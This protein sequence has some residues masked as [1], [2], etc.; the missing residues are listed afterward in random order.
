MNTYGPAECSVDVAVGGP[1]Q[2]PSDASTIGFPL[3]VCL[4]V[5][6]PSNYNR[7]VPIGTPGEL[8]VEGPQLAREYLNSPRKTDESFISDPEFVKQLGIP[9]HR[10]FY[11]TGDLVR[12]NTDGSLIH[13]G[14]IDTQIKIRGQRVEIGEIESNILRLEPKVRVACVDLIQLSDTDR[15]PMLLAAVEV[16][17]EEGEHDGFTPGP[18]R[19]PTDSLRALIRNLQAE[20]LLVLPRY[21]VPHFVPMVRLQLNASGKLDRRATR[22]TLEAMTREQVALFEEACDT[23]QERTTLSAMEER[24]RQIWVELLG[25]SPNVGPDANFT[26]LGGDSVIAMRHVAAA[27]RVGIQ[28]GV[29]DILHN[30]RLSDLASIAEQ[31]QRLGAS[32][33]DSAPLELWPG[34]TDA[35]LEEQ[36]RWLEAVA[37]QCDERSADIEDVYPATAQQEGLMALTAQQPGAFVAQNV[38]RLTNVDITR[39]KQTWTRLMKSLPILR[40]RIV[41]HNSHSGSLQVVVRR[42][43]HW[44]HATDLETY[45]ATDK[46][47]PFSYGTP[48]HRLAIIE[49]RAAGV[50]G[51][52]FVWTQHHSGYDG[53]QTALMLNMLAEVHQG[54]ELHHSSPP[55]S[56]FVRYLQHK[57]KDKVTAFWRKQLGD[58]SLAR[59]PELPTA[60]YR[61]QADSSSRRLI[62]RSTSHN[63]PPVSALLRAAWA[64]TVTTYTGSTESTSAVALSGRDIPVDGIGSMAMPTLTTVPVRTR[65][66]NRKQTVLA[67]LAGITRQSEEMIPFL[68]TG[69]QHIRASVPRLGADYD[70]G[71][72]FI[73]QPPLGGNDEDPLA[74]IGLEDV[75]T[76]RTDFPGCAL[77]VQCTINADGPV[78][79][80]MRYDSKVV[81]T[82]MA[83]NLLVQFAYIVHQL[84][85]H[86]DTA[87]GDLD[88][89]RPADTQK[90]HK[91]NQ[92]VLQAKPI[93]SCVHHLIQSMVDRQPNADAVCAWDGALSYAALWA[94][95]CRLAHHLVELGVGPE[96]SVGICM[97]KS[98]WAMVSM[99]A[100]LQAGGVVVALGTQHPLIR[101]KTILADAAIK[102][103]LVDKSQADRLR[104]VTD[105]LVV[106]EDSVDRLPSQSEPLGVGVTPHNAAWIVYTS[107]STGTPKGVVLEHQ[108]LCTGIIAHGTRFGNNEQ[109]RALQFASHTFGVVVEDMFTTLVFGGCTCIPSE[110]QKMNMHELATMIRDTG[111]NFMNLT[112][113]A[114]SLLDPRDVPGVK[115]VVVGGESLRPAVVQQWAEHAKLLNAYGQSECCVES[116]ISVVEDEKDAANIGFPI[117]GCAVWVVDPLDYN[118]LVPVGVAGELLIQ[119]PLLARGYLNDPDKTAASFVPSSDFLQRL[120]FSGE[121]GSRM[122]R[123]GDL[124]KQNDDGSIDYL[125]RRDTQIKIRGQRVECGEIENRIVQLQ[126]EVSH[127]FVDLIAPCDADAPCDPVLVAAVEFHEGFR[128]FLPT[129]LTDLMQSVGSGL[130]QQLPAYMVPNY[131]VPMPNHFPVNA[132]GKLDRRATRT[133]LER[134]SRDQLAAYKP[135][136]KHPQRPLSPLEERLR[137]V[138][139][140]V[141]S[142]PSDSIG[143]YDQFVQLGG[144]S[145][146][147]MR[148]V[149]AARIQGLSLSVRDILLHQSIAA[150]SPYMTSLPNALDT[151]PP[152]DSVTDVQKWMLNHHVARPDVG[153]TWF[154]LDAAGPLI[155]GRMADA[156][157]KLLATIEIL[158]TGFV[159]RDREWKRVVPAAVQ[160]E[161]QSFRTDTTISKWT[162]EY[163]KRKGFRPIDGARPLVDIALCTTR[164]EHT[165]LISMSHA[166][167][168]GMCI[169]SFWSSLKDLYET[170]RT[171]PRSSFSQYIGQVEKGRTAEA[172]R[173]WASLLQ[174]ATL[175]SV[176][177]VTPQDRE[178]VW[179]AGLIG[180]TAVEIGGKLPPGTT[181]AT[182]LKSAWALVLARH[183]GRNDVTFADLVSGR[184]GVDAS[185]ADVLG[186]CS[187]PI[188]VRVQLDP[189]WTFVDLVR[190]VQKQQVDSMPFETYGF[191]KIVG[192]CTDWPEESRPPSWI[193]HVPRKIADTISIGGTGYTISQPAQEEQKWTFSET[194][195]S[196]TQ[197]E[198]TLEVTLVYAAEKVAEE[199]AEG[200]FADLVSML[201]RILSYPRELISV[202]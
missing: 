41:Y 78:D 76:A 186:M 33:E 74:V 139:A 155:G 175:T 3:N 160:P 118:R 10:R 123:T 24:L 2:S 99:L 54:K 191:S 202:A 11:R 20:L 112:S 7:L 195:V 111:V 91:W 110:D 58:V 48:L 27:M 95:S 168:D 185:V 15:D 201:E 164:W 200:L 187:T 170:G 17:G 132:S 29:A 42:H 13:L 86:P 150:L 102:V 188:P 45:L 120:G 103:T 56:R 46:T 30:P 169:T 79:V 116:L 124:V 128:P 49:P 51:M 181:C 126:A 39:F 198:D 173:Y 135:K 67:L 61:P 105:Y 16:S 9:S 59:F 75:S 60:S 68:H 106:D 151:L 52:Y 18:A 137:T 189:A 113:T 141:L 6:S 167:Y 36:K 142:L 165:I 143:I 176:G 96:V 72:L 129:D 134:I 100:V 109:T 163:I 8:L 108:T 133:V 107:G 162:A 156:C 117:A 65:L 97:D 57:D 4:W 87:I 138:Y 125:G 92:A 152:S 28:I 70:P 130:L 62:Q 23:A 121:V 64:F 22:M 179:E 1:M 122:Y 84:E 147:A 148:A 31:S 50:D 115:T 34:F 32:E 80:E 98:V 193:N 114:A 82:R 38:F 85:T 104:D 25:C 101:L 161:V 73:I 89:L 184:Y 55:I 158:H 190:A 66:D 5:T 69:M 93:A 136:Q 166:I 146:A 197:I 40:T 77:A 53:Y 154:A 131:I 90:I 44:I 145:V 88:M 26:Q 14:R 43:L 149:A 19:R 119:G 157:R 81:A 127:A 140:E 21:M 153:M 196:W 83:E 183:T 172:S 171:T 47:L 194:R 174:N 94:T 35:D 12:Q 182:V 159:V 144:D 178:F 37:Q 63:G 180:P 199:V 192:E 177:N 71:H